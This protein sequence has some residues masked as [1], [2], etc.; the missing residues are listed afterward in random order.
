MFDD[1]LRIRDASGLKSFK[2]EYH[3]D[4]SDKKIVITDKK[5]QLF[6]SEE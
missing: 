5:P 1:Y 3:A 4:E 6:S 2:N